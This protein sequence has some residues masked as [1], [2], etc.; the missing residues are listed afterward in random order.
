MNQLKEIQVKDSQ[1]LTS[2]LSECR[3]RFAL[4]T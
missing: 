4:G 3:R 1:Q 2:N